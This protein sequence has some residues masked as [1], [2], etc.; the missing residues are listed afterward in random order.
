[1]RPFLVKRATQNPVEGGA[2][3]GG[4]AHIVRGRMPTKRMQLGRPKV[5]PRVQE[6]A[7]QPQLGA[8]MSIHDSL[9]AATHTRP[10]AS[11][12]AVPPQPLHRLCHRGH[13]PCTDRLRSLVKLDH[14]VRAYHSFATVDRRTNRSLNN[15]GKDQEN[16]GG[17]RK[18]H[19][20]DSRFQ[21]PGRSPARNNSSTSVHSEF[22]YENGSAMAE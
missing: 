16:C 3:V 8:S 4:C 1:M 15:G 22:I 21:A 10:T 11:S 18:T 13:T 14:L 6:F 2:A 7:A 19:S 9:I 20:G 17:V 12:L 5:R